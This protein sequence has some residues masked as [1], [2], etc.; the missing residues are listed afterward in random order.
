MIVMK[1]GGSSVANRA[2]IEKVRAIVEARASRHPLVVSSAHKGMTDALI[3]AARRAASG[4]YDPDGPIR[5]QRAIAEECGCPPD[6]LEPLVAEIADLLRGISLVRELSPRSLDYVASFGER[7]AVRVIADLFT[8]GGLAAQ[9]HDVW[10]LGFLTDANYGSARPI[11]GFEAMVRDAVASR[12]EPGVIPIVTGF[13]GKT[14]DGDITTVGRNGSDLTCTLLA[15]A[16]G[17]EEA[18]VWSDTDGVMTADPSVV[19]SARSIPR[20]TF[21]EAAELA[22]FGSRVLHP[23]TLLPARNAGIPVRVLNTN[24]PEHPGTVIDDVGGASARGATSI[25]YKERQTVLTV[26][27]TRMF[28]EYGFLSRVFEILGRHHV[29]VDVVTTSEISISIT[30]HERTRLDAALPELLALGRTEVQHGRA[31]LVVVGRDLPTRIGL[32]GEVFS[33][34]ASVE[35]NLEMIHHAMGSISLGMVV[36]DA[37]V[38]AA[39]STLHALLFEGA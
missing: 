39:V 15:A 36:K 28:G 14:L 1:F 26:T 13:I 19:K 23:E 20:M 16:L 8:R 6:L 38:G 30:T 2:Q 3:D 12:V 25:A 9:A 31:I 33:V 11:P 5:K 24:R 37:D 27:S 35:V 34:M 4:Q 29:V 18:E 7:M 21:D 22:Y 10:D 32:A 17:A